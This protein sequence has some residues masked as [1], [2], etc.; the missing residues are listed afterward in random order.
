MSRDH[1]ER[2]QL[3]FSRAVVPRASDGDIPKLTLPP[4]CVRELKSGGIWKGRRKTRRGRTRQVSR[5]TVVATDDD[6]RG[7]SEASAGFVFDE[8]AEKAPQSVSHRAKPQADE[9]ELSLCHAT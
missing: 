3:L 5:D 8:R 6:C 2:D 4:S 1:A 7:R 9:R